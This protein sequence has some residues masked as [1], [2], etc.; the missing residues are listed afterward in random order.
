MK[1]GCMPVFF[2]PKPC[3]EKNPMHIKSCFVYTLIRR[4]FNPLSVSHKSFFHK[5][6]RIFALS[7][8]L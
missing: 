7:G 2:L 3:N 4:L 5:V 1:D 8:T 6:F